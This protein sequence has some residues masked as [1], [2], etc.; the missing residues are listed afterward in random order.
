MGE[1]KEI[2]EDTVQK[3]QSTEN[4]QKVLNKTLDKDREA[5]ETEQPVKEGEKRKGNKVTKHPKEP[6]HLTS[7]STLHCHCEEE[8]V[9]L[10][11]S[12]EHCQKGEGGRHWG[13]MER[14]WERA[15][16]CNKVC[17]FMDAGVR[18]GGKQGGV[19][20]LEDRTESYGSGVVDRLVGALKNTSMHNKAVP[21]D[22]KRRW[23]PSFPLTN[24]CPQL[25]P[26]S[27]SLCA[28]K[29]TQTLTHLTTLATLTILGLGKT[30]RTYAA[31]L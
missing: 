17:K 3:V 6:S 20:S 28:L 1:E 19:P 11:D 7:A 23:A 8:L 22:V 14:V 29:H 30:L 31:L 25:P 13:L 26:S 18:C 21:A 24:T 27:S 4:W 10:S 15:R 5:G 2:T 9:P 12:L 16:W